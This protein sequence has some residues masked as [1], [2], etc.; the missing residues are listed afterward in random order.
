[1]L[2]ELHL[3][4]HNQE[5]LINGSGLSQNVSTERVSKTFTDNIFIYI[6]PKYLILQHKIHSQQLQNISRLEAQVTPCLRNYHLTETTI[7]T[8]L[9]QRAL[10]ATQDAH[11]GLQSQSPAL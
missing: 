8:N 9:N 5:I 6:L 11:P 10:A 2:P 1:M 7:Y 4:Q 3:Y